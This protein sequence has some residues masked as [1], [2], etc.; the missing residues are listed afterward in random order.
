MWPGKYRVHITTYFEGNI[1]ADPP[2]PS[3]AEKVPAKYNTESELTAEVKA[4]EN[5]IPFELL[6]DDDS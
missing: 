2:L 5:V 1:E 3:V 4:E 6:S